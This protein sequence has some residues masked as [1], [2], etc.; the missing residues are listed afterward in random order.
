MGKL[1]PLFCKRISRVTDRSLLTEEYNSTYEL[2]EYMVQ[3]EKAELVKII[4]NKLRII[5]YRLCELEGEE[6]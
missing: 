2:V 1:S 4:Q 3:N 5:S 6:Q